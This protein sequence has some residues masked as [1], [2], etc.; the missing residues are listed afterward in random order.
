M[1]EALQKALQYLEA[2]I[3]HA[4]QTGNARLPRYRILAAHAGVSPCT[5]HKAIA[6]VKKTGAITVSHGKG[7]RVTSLAPDL[8]FPRETTGST[9]STRLAQTIKK[10]LYDGRYYS[11]E[12]SISIKELTQSYGTCYR[13]MRKALDYLIEDGV[14][15]QHKQG[16]LQNLRSASHTRNT[17][18][19]IVRGDHFGDPDYPSNRT[20]DHLRT[21]QTL[22]AH[23]RLKLIITTCY[24]R[25]TSL[26]GIEEIRHLITS[27]HHATTLLGFIVWG[28]SIEPHYVATIIEEILRN[29]KPVAL[30]DETGNI[31]LTHHCRRSHFFRKYPLAISACD[32]RIAA[33]Y[34]I[35]KGHRHIA[36]IGYGNH[37]HFSPLRLHSAI[38]EY[39]SA[40]L[41]DGVIPF[42]LPHLPLLQMQDIFHNT[43]VATN[44]RSMQALGE[45]ISHMTGNAIKSFTVRERMAFEL[46]SHLS[47]A[48]RRQTLRDYIFPL[49]RN[50]VQHREITAWLCC[51]DEVALDCLDFLRFEGVHVPEEISVLGFDDSFDAFT[52]QLSSMNFNGEGCLHACVAHILHPD[53]DPLSRSGEEPAGFINERRTTGPPRVRQNEYSGNES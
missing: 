45:L 9:R 41:P 25:G 6:Y 19:L 20:R 13:T 43:A 26:C 3:E 34:L 10:H 30:L 50:V 23:A 2:S 48:L 51:N 5:M 22:C 32:G 49:C 27:P 18:V 44:P 1:S 53:P 21:L 8:P 31:P 28:I 29:D 7:I 36:Y 14:I 46:S 52:Q 12:K 4:L 37:H 38:N 16:V 40:G 17:I 11:K 42:E 35:E 15:T 24:Y 47:R 33:R 39:A